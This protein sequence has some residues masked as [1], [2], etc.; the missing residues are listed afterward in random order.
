MEDE[1]S[2]KHLRNIAA[3]RPV[4][5][6]EPRELAAA[7]M[8]YF[9]YTDQETKWDKQNWAGKDGK[10]VVVK[11]KSPYTK[12]GLV[13]HMGIDMSTFDNYKS[14][15]K[16]NKESMSKNEC[17]IA[18]Q[19]FRLA[20][21]IEAIIRNK[22]IAGALTGHYQQNIVARLNGLVDRQ[23]VT[24]NDKEINTLGGVKV[25]LPEGMTLQQSPKIEDA[26]I[27]EDKPALTVKKRTA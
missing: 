15:Y 4:I 9:K 8:A 16:N 7:A 25:E 19:F 24:S 18:L 1:P 6:K 2:F 23:D 20:I 3:G 27:I 17:K 14:N 13:A 5:F 10:E 21:H 12:Y 22:Q 26:E 11:V